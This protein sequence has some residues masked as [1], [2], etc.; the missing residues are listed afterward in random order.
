MGW[1][2][3]RKPEPA[4]PFLAL[5]ADTQNRERLSSLQWKVGA[6]LCDRRMQEQR[7]AGERK[8]EDVVGHGWD[9]A[10]PG[11]ADSSHLPSPWG[12]YN[13]VLSRYGALG[14]GGWEPRNAA[15]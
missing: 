14:W 5:K 4:P 15:G 7:G 11:L 6:V 13:P 8:T 10:V 12:D 1:K 2:G 9:N 3:P